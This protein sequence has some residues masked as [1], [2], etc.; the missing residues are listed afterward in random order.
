MKK[1]DFNLAVKALIVRDSKILLI[2]RSNN[3][4]HKPGVWEFPGG[5]LERGENPQKGLKREVKEET[6]LSINVLNPLTVA[7][8]TRDDK[9]KITMITFLC[10]SKKGDVKLGKEHTKAEW[11]GIRKAR[12]MIYP[13]FREDIDLYEKHFRR[14]LG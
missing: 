7:Q 9:Q 11:L 6:G 1:N 12:S 3:D 13:A 4:S 5:R 10:S 14:F 8:F 2:K